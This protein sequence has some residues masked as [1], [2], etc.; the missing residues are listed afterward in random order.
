MADTSTNR[1][2]E[3]V[4]GRFRITGTVGKGAMGAVYAAEHTGTGQRVA[5]K[6][7][8]LDGDD[9]AEFVARFEQEARVMAGLKHPN[10]IRIYD[11]GTA[12]DGQMFMAMEL[13]AGQGL[14]KVIRENTRQGATM[15]EAEAANYAI[16]IL[17][18]LA[19]AHGQGLVH[20]DLKPGNVMLTDDG[21]GEILC[22]VLDFGIARTSNS[23]MT[24]SGRLLGT[25]SYMAPESW[26]GSKVDLRADL[27]AVGCILYCCV[28]GGPPF[29]AGDNAMALMTKHLHEAPADPRQR[30]KQPLSE[31]FVQV[32]QTALAKNPAARYADARAMRQALEAA[33]GGAWA[34]TPANLSPGTPLGLRRPTGA[35][36]AAAVA[37]ADQATVALQT[38]PRGKLVAVAGGTLALDA[39]ATPKSKL[40][41]LVGAVLAVVA[42]GAGIWAATRGPAPAPAAAAMPAAAPT[43]APEPAPAPA[44]AAVPGPVPVPTP[45]PAAAPAPAVAPEPGAAA[46]TAAAPAATTVAKPTAAKPSPKKAAPA[47]KPAAPKK[48]GLNMV[49]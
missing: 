5:L 27:Y 49:D 17:K 32:V 45:A 9:S 26:Q 2:G 11:F 12:S 28:T 22:K 16:Q 19:E 39:P 33:I 8:A 23:D 42:I 30:A 36:P 48:G 1:L 21:G 46:P 15:G 25:P 34:G 44:A 29:S 47:D 18:S 40:P 31:A 41:L 43:A 6:F 35:Q 37:P 4:A 14:D 7:M 20:R 10:T 3:V 13:L 24:G 38:D